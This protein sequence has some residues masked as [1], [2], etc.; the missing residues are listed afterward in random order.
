MAAVL[1]HSPVALP[2]IRTLQ[3]GKFYPPYMGGMETHLQALCENLNPVIKVQAVV[4]NSNR[5]STEDWVRGIKVIRAGTLFNLSAAPVCPEMVS[6]IRRSDADI[7]H[8]HLPNP[9]AVMAY[10]ASRQR[11]KLIVTY[12]SDVVRQKLLNNAF[13][14][15]LNLALSRCSAIIATSPDYLATSPVLAAH[16]DRC[17]V[18]PYGIPVEQ[19][20]QCDQT[21]VN[22]IRAKYGERLIISVGR[23]V[24]YKGFEFLIR[25]MAN[26]PDARLLIIGDGPLRAALEQ[27][28][29]ECGVADRVVFLGELQNEETI[30]YYHAADIFAL[31]S[32]ARSEAFGIVQLEAMACGKPVINT[33]LDSGVPF[34]SLD[35]VSGLTV[36]PK[37]SGAM[38]A[39]I[40]KLLDNPALR[41]QYG[42]AARRRVREEFALEV[43]TRRM[44]RLY[45][46]VVGQSKGLA[47]HSPNGYSVAGM[48][49]EAIGQ[50]AGVAAYNGNHA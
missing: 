16:R 4:A 19:F 48:A 15:I 1:A 29:R 49:N 3:V 41:A 20:E 21:A 38:A 32:I 50:T 36:P 10:L 40:N 27:E 13:N 23:L 12:H 2:N 28:A 34:V 46:Q 24:Y 44:L 42:D 14:P 37:D 18:I 9:M 30:P 45:S 22:R 33:Q 11:A 31:A 17:H 7:I 8:L 5:Q 43:M 6:L 35:G 25:S 47:A 26:V 39:A